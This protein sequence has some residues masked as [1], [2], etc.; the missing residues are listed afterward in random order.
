MKK[1]KYLLIIIGSAIA[2]SFI[3]TYKLIIPSEVHALV[4]AQDD[5]ES[6]NEDNPVIQTIA[7]TKSSLPQISTTDVAATPQSIYS[8][9]PSTLVTESSAPL[10]LPT[11]NTDSENKPSSWPWYITRA[12]GITSLI[13]LTLLVLLGLGIT[14]GIAYRIMSPIVAWTYHRLIGILLAFSVVTHLVALLFD[15]FVSF[16]LMQIL[17]PF[18][19]TY[20]PLTVSFGIL[21]FYILL[22]V[23]ITSLWFM[24]K[25]KSWRLLHYLSILIFI[26][27]IVHGYFT[28]TDSRGLVMKLIYV[29]ASLV[30]LLM[31]YIRIAH[32][33]ANV[34]KRQ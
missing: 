21:S 3:V 11:T 15:K 29:L 28:G 24:N 8:P 7:T 23:L 31:M 16:N 13:L 12:A 22:T 34:K 1:P 14:T 33:M 17:I 25:Y 27:I 20:R 19:A 10:I 5:D 26:L 4:Y 6:E 18:T 32:G 2:L 30:F 9:N